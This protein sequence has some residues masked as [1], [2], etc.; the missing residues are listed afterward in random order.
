MASQII[1]QKISW[2]AVSTIKKTKQILDIILALVASRQVLNSTAGNLA[3]FYLTLCA[4]PCKNW[5]AERDSMY[6]AVSTLHF[7]NPRTGGGFS[8]N[9]AAWVSPSSY[10]NM[11]TTRQWVFQALWWHE[12]FYR[13]NECQLQP[14]CSLLSF[15]TWK[16][17]HQSSRSIG[18][19]GNFTCSC[20]EA[21]IVPRPVKNR[22]MLLLS[23]LTF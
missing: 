23:R 10:L 13:Q 16:I 19:C 11:D 1:L 5:Q 7:L 8:R 6:W 14:L 4:S 2:Q 22:R 17:Y 9:S 21:K 3:E 12:L 20:K 15:A 18:C